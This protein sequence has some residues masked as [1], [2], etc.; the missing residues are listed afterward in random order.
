MTKKRVSAS[1]IHVKQDMY[2]ALLSLLE[3]K[4]L[5]TITVSDI[6]SEASVSRMSFYRNYNSIE[7]ILTEHLRDVV[8][9]YKAEDIE[10]IIEEKEQVYYGKGYMIHCFKFFYQH[11]DFIDTLI[12]CGMGDLFLAE[13]TDYL[14]EK[15]VPEDNKNR[16][17][18]LKI[19][20]YA[21]SIYN[22]YREWGKT[23]FKELPEDIAFILYDIQ[24][25]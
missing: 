24:K 10:G 20:A 6:T 2:R 16:E 23:S 15:W 17:T 5:S 4:K 7:D 11:H 19:S 9:E 8:A 21:G 25:K 12:S 3:R 14:I 13:I 22:M 18:V 1:N